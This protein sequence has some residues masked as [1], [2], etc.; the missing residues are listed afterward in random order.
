M[1]R[2]TYPLVFAL[3]IIRMHHALFSLPCTTPSF[4]LVS[5]FFSLDLD[6]YF[7]YPPPYPFL[8]FS[9][10]RGIVS[11]EVRLV[12][13][14]ASASITPSRLGQAQGGLSGGGRLLWFPLGT[15][16]VGLIPNVTVPESSPDG[17]LD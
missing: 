2:Q 15:L 7:F 10:L 3:G 1:F 4:C 6:A 14:L 17:S 16:V 11:K 5:L 13:T 9:L 12:L 8:F